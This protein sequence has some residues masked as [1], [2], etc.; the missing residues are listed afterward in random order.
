MPNLF[1]PFTLKGVTLRNRIVMSPMT[2]YRSVD[3]KMDDYHVSYLGARAAGGFGLVFP[4][5]LAITPDGRTTVSCG[6]IYDESQLEGLERVCS[7]IKSMGGVAAIQLGHTGRK[8]S[9]VTPW[10]GGYMLPPDHPNGWQTKAPSAIAYGGDLPYAPEAL[11]IAEIQDIYASYAQ[12]A[13]WAVEVGFEW[14][15]MHYAHGY[16]GAEFFSPLANTRTDAYGGSLEN[17]A[18]FHLEALDAVKAVLPDRIPLTMRL[19]SDDLNPEGTQFDDSVVAIGWMKEH[20]L[21]LADLSF[22][23]NT[24]DMRENIFNTPG[25]FVERANRVRRE[26]GI[27]VGA[28]WNLGK[29][30]NADDVIQKELIDL[31]FLGRP[32][33]SN[34][35]WPVWAARELGYDNPF[36]LVPDDWGWWLRNFRAD[37][38]SIGFPAVSEDTAG[39][40]VANATPTQGLTVGTAPVE[41]GAVTLDGVPADLPDEEERQVA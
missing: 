18:R 39:A 13:K 11:T 30:Q 6:G 41:P 15:E 20:G 32:A 22:G 24:D 12:S 40:P 23:G 8:G 16:L 28:S 14:I 7:I 1:S 21:D 37:Q 31:A 26:V 35:H 9:V 27:P 2:M 33:L 5:Q 36:G 34:P 25:A 10:E 3:G 38:E 29:P 17:R 4:E 19:G